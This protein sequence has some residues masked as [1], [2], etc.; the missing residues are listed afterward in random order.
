MCRG[1]WRAVD[2]FAT[3]VYEL[4]RYGRGK[5]RNIFIHGPANCRK[6]FLFH[7]LKLVYKTFLNPAHGT[8]AWVGVDEREVIFLND[9]RWSPTLIAWETF[10]CFVGGGCHAFAWAKE[11]LRQINRNQGQCSHHCNVGYAH[12]LC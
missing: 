2:E 12:L 10:S 4:L 8:F 5:F 3:A 7:P 9:F 6:L 1:L 11:C